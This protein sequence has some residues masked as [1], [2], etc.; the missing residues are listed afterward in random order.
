M[1]HYVF[2]MFSQTHTIS[3]QEELLKKIFDFSQK[4]FDGKVYYH[5]PRIFFFDSLLDRPAFEKWFYSLSKEIY[6]FRNSQFGY[7]LYESRKF[8]EIEPLYFDPVL[9]YATS[10]LI[11]IFWLDMYGFETESFEELM[12]F[13][14]QK[15]CGLDK[16]FKS[17]GI[18]FLSTDQIRQLFHYR[19]ENNK[20]M[21][22]NM[23]YIVGRFR[24]CF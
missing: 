10:E 15:G 11:R 16:V 19:H 8:N 22:R 4:Y 21:F 24:E 6:Q 17:L 14:S 5:F 20:Y 9:E 7:R 23:C 18:K 12:E 3:E 1:Y 2:K 13:D